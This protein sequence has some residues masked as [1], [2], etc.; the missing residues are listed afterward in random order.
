[1]EVYVLHGRPHHF[2]AICVFLPISCHQS[3]S[4]GPSD[5]TRPFQ[6]GFYLI[7]IIG[8]VLILG[9]RLRWQAALLMPIYG[10]AALLSSPCFLT[11]P[12]MERARDHV[13]AARPRDLTSPK[14]GHNGPLTGYTWPRDLSCDLISLG[15]DTCVRVMGVTS[16]V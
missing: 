8:G 12:Y 14:Y 15:P 11:S 1:M 10:D 2:I 3:Q 5:S 7:P 9:S 6:S 13:T 16:V 4:A